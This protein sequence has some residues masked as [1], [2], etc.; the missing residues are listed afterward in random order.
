M[1]RDLLSSKLIIFGVAFF[2]ICV[3]GSLIWYSQ[4]QREIE[5]SKSE[6]ARVLKY[7]ES[8]KVPDQSTPRAPKENTEIPQQVAAPL[9]SEE[10]ILA[11]TDFKET[12]SEMAE[13]TDSFK[14][15]TTLL[16]EETP[17]EAEIADVHV[18]SFGLGIYPEIPSDYPEQDVWD[19]VSKIEDP[20]FGRQIELIERTRIKLWGQGTETVGAS[21]SDQTGRIYPNIPNV[22][23][24]RWEE[25]VEPDGTRSRY[26]SLVS[27][28]PGVAENQHYFDKGEVPPGI[29]VIP[30]DEAGV[31]PYAFL[32]FTYE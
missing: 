7:L 24:V 22:A 19:R 31:D 20:E 29:T 14:I 15:E 8:K 2:L 4:V 17:E 1:L 25:T 10:D 32:E 28:G 27:G 21:Y 18:S 12:P 26:A 6:N 3:G 11:E 23:Y 9:E 13:D 30:Y 5:E 16:P